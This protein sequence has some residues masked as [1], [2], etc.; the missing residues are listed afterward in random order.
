VNRPLSACSTTVAVALLA[1]GCGSSSKTS[2]YAATSSPPAS[3]ATAPTS[4]PPATS[5][6]SRPTAGALVGTKHIKLGTV[7]AAGPKMRTVY[8]FEADKGGVSACTGAC[9]HAWPPVTTTG[10]P[11]AAGTALSADLGTISRPDGTM[12]VTYK[13]HPLYFYSTD[14]DASDSYGQ[15]IKSFGADWYVLAPTGRKIDK[16]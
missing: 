5:S 8:L 12:Q 11:K 16:A 13:G 1:A 2:P 9:T 3:A 14:M 15:G 10:S 6:T 7:L 4:T